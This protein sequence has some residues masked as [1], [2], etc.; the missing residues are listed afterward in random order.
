M[1][2]F[3]RHT[4]LVTVYLLMITV[5]TACSLPTATPRPSTPT[6]T[7]A[8][9]AGTESTTAT[10]TDIP[11]P[12]PELGEEGNPI[13]LALPPAQFLDPVAIAKTYEAAGAAAVSV[14]TDKL[15]FQGGIDVGREGVEFN[16]LAQDAGHA[17]LQSI[18]R[19]GTRLGGEQQGGKRRLMRLS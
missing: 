7:V 8:A 18:V 14:L 19:E 17:H 4:K 13:L 3:M 16:G 6:A 10:A 5:L 9:P 2:A 1:I 11:T 15:F 12:A